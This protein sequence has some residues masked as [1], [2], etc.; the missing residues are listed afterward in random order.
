[1]I[2]KCFILCK[3]WFR[4]DKLDQYEREVV[5]YFKDYNWINQKILCV[6]SKLLLK[7]NDEK[8]EKDMLK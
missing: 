7:K 8:K 6:L 2:E 5:V 3:N 4:F 1:M